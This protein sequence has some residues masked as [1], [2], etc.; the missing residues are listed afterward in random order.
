M[1][2]IGANFTM[3]GDGKV[4][5]LEAF[6]LD[7]A[8]SAMAMWAMLASPLMIGADMRSMAPEYRAIWL[9]EELIRVSQDPLGQQG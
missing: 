5:A 2:P 7:Q 9:N 4:V 8:H 3:N 1:L 6:T